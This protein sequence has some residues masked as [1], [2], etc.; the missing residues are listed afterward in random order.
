MATQIQAAQ[1]HGR[2]QYYISVSVTIHASSM[3]CEP[4][5]KKHSRVWLEKGRA[6]AAVKKCYCEYNNER[7]INMKYI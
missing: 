7:V 5:E 3:N 4:T 2:R 6:A 1:K